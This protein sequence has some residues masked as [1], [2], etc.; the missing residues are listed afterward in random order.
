MLANAASALAA[1]CAKADAKQ[2]AEKVAEL[3]A[4]SSKGSWGRVR[5]ATLAL[6]ELG[7]MVDLKSSPAAFDALMTATVGTAS[8]ENEKDHK[9][10]AALS[11][12]LVA[13]GSVAAFLPALLEALEKAKDDDSEYLLLAAT[14]EVAAAADPSALAPFVDRVADRLVRSADAEAEPTRAMVADCLGALAPIA[15]QAVAVRLDALLD[16]RK[17]DEPA[18]TKTG[19]DDEDEDAANALSANPAVRAS[20][21]AAAA[22][23]QA[24]SV[25]AK[26]EAPDFVAIIAPR[27]R[28]ALELVDDAKLDLAVRRQALVV[29]NACAHHRPSLIAPLVGEAV[30]KLRSVVD[31]KLERVVDLGPFKHKVDDGLPVRKAAVACVATF[32]DHALAEESPPPV[33]SD[34][35]A[36]MSDDAASS[37]VK[38]NEFA[39]VAPDL[40]PVAVVALADKSEDV[41]MLAHSFV[42]KLCEAVPDAVAASAPALFE[43][44]DKTV[45]KKVSAKSGTDAD[46]AYDLIRSA[47]KAALA[48]NDLPDRPPAAQ[49]FLDKANKKD[50]LAAEIAR[51]TNNQAPFRGAETGASS[52]S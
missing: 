38:S 15:P 4:Q 44:L 40:V 39:R 22:L 35:D 37:A 23:K 30:P 31:L 24:C 51:L 16:R 36:Q 48:L 49:A 28:R 25:T 50:K 12:G 41:Q 52:S 1:L 34:G 14:K 13:S 29:L 47:L 21:T 8:S 46:R 6:G 45:H 9:T 43:A 18:K 42:V 27:L 33:D 11:L 32:V 3:V 10:S 2:R 7:K 19:D 20:W 5:L 26:E 17:G